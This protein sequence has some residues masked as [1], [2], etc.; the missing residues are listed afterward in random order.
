MK[1]FLQRIGAVILGVISGFDRIRLRG[2]LPRLVDPDTFSTWLYSAGV[3]LK[4]FGTYTEGVTK[5]VRKEI[6]ARAEQ[7]GRP[8][9]YLDRYT[10][11]EALVQHRLTRQGAAPIDLHAQHPGKLLLVYRAP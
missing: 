5:H 1:S 6:E 8:V 2:T 7:Q 10:D 11:K 3:P 4:D 9:E